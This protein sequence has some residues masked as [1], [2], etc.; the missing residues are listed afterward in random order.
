MPKSGRVYRQGQN[1]WDNFVE[2]GI[3]ENEVFFTDDPIVTAHAIGKTKATIGE[4][5]PIDAAV[6]YT[7][8]SAGPDARLTSKDMVN[9]H[10]RMATAMMSGTVGYGS[11]TDPRQESCGHDEIEGYNVVLHDIYCA[12]GLIKI[13][14]YKKSTHDTSL[15]DKMS[16]DML[17]M[18]SFRVSKAWW[19]RNM[20]DRNWNNKGKHVNYI[21]LLQTDK[22]LPIKKFAEQTFG[23]KKWHLSEDH[24]PYEVKFTRGECAWADDP[25]KRCAHHQPE[26][27]DGW[28]MVRA[29]DD[30]GDIVE[31][32]SRDED[33][34]PIPAFEKIWKRGKNVRAVHSGWNRRMFEKKNLEDAS[35]E[36]VVL[37]DRVSRGLGNT[38]PE[39]DVIKA[40]NAACRRMTARNFNVVT[41]IGLRNS[42]TY[43][44][45]EWDWLYT[46]KA[47]IAQTSKKNRKEHDLVNG[48]KWTK[49]QSR[50]SYGYEI[51]KF[52]WVPGKVNDEYDSATH[53]SVQWKEGVAVTTYTTPPAVKDTFRI[54]KIKISTGYYG[55]KEMPWVW[56][57]KEEAEQYLSFNTMLAGRTGAVNSGQRVWDGSLGQELLDS[58]DGFS[59]VS[60]DFA[61]RLEMDMGVDPEELP[62]ATEVFEALMWGTPQEFDAAYALLSENAQS[63]WKRPEIKNVEEN[64]TGGQEVVAA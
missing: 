41:K 17:A 22:F 7:L 29:V 4:C 48:W 13:S 23:T 6:A 25:D 27:Y 38:V 53:K 58:Y 42:A 20:Q 63:H 26:S 11:I 49:Y 1:G 3:V 59:V 9:Q 51:A 16:P 33:G 10:T 47:W 61:E 44:W 2:A 18:M 45:K 24:A 14:K 50:R 36:R 54:W 21:R 52:K 31:F 30:Y 60:V 15:K 64:D 57:T 32:G 43:H 8:A 46:L 62:T 5:W 40:I 55:G 28:A 35:P 34:N 39:K 19:S 56:K 12:N 37:W